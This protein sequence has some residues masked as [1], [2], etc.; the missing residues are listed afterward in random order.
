MSRLSAALARVPF[1]VI[2]VNMAQPGRN[3]CKGETRFQ[4][5]PET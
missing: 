4:G 1:P 3:S 5:G 2:G